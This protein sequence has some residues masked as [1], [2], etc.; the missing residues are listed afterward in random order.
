MQALGT[1]ANSSGTPSNAAV[2]RAPA[3][4]K[5]REQDKV[6][7]LLQEQVRALVPELKGRAQFHRRAPGGACPNFLQTCT[8][9]QHTHTH[10]HTHTHT[11]THTCTHTRTHARTHIHTH[12]HGGTRTHT[13]T[14]SYAHIPAQALLF[15][16]FCSPTCTP[17]GNSLG[18]QSRTTRT[19]AGTKAHQPLDQRRVKPK[20]IG[21]SHSCISR[22][23]HGATAA[24]DSSPSKAT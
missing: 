7:T 14:Q 8:H 17:A 9:K 12:T 1:S 3:T 16:G 18:C 21:I 20:R 19:W 6:V 10:A 24:A 23:C 4:D 15:M 2:L 22:S 11:H 5:A 13:R